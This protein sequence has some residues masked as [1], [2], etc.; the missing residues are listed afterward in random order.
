MLHIIQIMGYLA[1]IEYSGDIVVQGV[2]A[3]FMKNQQIAMIQV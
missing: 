3:Y 2:C 1:H